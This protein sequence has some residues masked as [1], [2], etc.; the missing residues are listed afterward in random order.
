MFNLFKKNKVQN[1]SK[2]MFYE[3]IISSHSG[4]SELPAML[5]SIK[6][7]DFPFNSLADLNEKLSILLYKNGDKTTS[8]ITRQLMFY[9]RKI[10]Q[11]YSYLLSSSEFDLYIDSVN[12]L[13]W[14]NVTPKYQKAFDEFDDNKK[15]IIKSIF[16]NIFNDL[17][18]ILKKIKVY[19][20]RY[21]KWL[22]HAEGQTVGTQY[23]KSLMQDKKYLEY[24][25]E[26]LAHDII[27]IKLIDVIWPELK[28]NI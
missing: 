28:R 11:S 18:P 14:L 12:P 10:A 25:K 13:N 2:W 1:N 17:K 5:S 9:Y 24:H 7:A 3:K 27:E 15:E 19:N 20:Y 6:E 23:I 26:L 16:L 4:Y 22:D 21:D 8:S